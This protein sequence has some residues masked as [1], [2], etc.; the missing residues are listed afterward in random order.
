MSGSLN[1]YKKNNMAKTDQTKGKTAPATN[2]Q[3]LTLQEVAQLLGINRNTAAAWRNAQVLPRPL[4]HTDTG[5]AY[6]S[7]AAVEAWARGAGSPG[8]QP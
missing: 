1:A 7:R 6:W 2:T 4:V 5:R 8:G 3:L